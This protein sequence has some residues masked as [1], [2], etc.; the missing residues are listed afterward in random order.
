MS[1]NSKT[2]MFYINSL[3]SGGAE[4]VIAQLSGAFSQAGYRCIL[5]TSYPGAVEYPVS[6]GVERICIENEKTEDGRLKKNLRRIRALRGYIRKYKPD[7]LISF[8]AEPNFRAIVAAAGLPVKTIVSV[9]NDPDR[10]YAGRLGKLVG[11]RLIPRADGCVF[12]TEQA[13]AWFDKGLQERSEVIMNQVSRSFFET[14]FDGERHYVVTA[15]RLNAQKNHAMLIRAF[16]RIADKTDENLRIYGA[17]DKKEEL[18]KLID[19]LGMRSRIE[20]M[21]LSRNIAEDIKDARLFV[22]PSDYEGMPNALLEAM[23]LSLPCISTACPCGGPEAII[24]DGEN[25]LLI[26][27]GDEDALCEA[28][29]S[30][31]G[32]ANFAR[33]LSENARQTAE[34][35][36]PE[37]VFEKW[38]GYVERVIS[39]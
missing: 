27:V 8:M 37:K 36:R 18:E 15:G 6:D 38:R 35:F 31:L 4:R 29:L 20:L 7:A 1:E 24:R 30:V 33:R 25:G 2:L 19:E 3:E 34:E 12:Q 39:R 17:G 13:R 21:G 5:V 10:E 22:L 11:K 23:A 28:M 9:R 14:E 32:D 16:S 26:P